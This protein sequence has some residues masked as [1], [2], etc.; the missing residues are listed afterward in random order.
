MKCC[1][2]LNTES[3]SKE[4]A[5]ENK[6]LFNGIIERNEPKDYGMLFLRE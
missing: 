4:N 5:A 1:V 3:E 2:W 6:V